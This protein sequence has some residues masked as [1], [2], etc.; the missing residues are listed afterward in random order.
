MVAYIFSLFPQIQNVQEIHIID[1][2][3]LFMLIFNMIIKIVANFLPL[4]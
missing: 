4:K 3:N 1:S 2:K